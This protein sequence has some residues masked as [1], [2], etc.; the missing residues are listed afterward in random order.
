MRILAVG[1]HPDD[2]DILCAGTLAKLAKRGDKIF[3]GIL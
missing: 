3:M 1:A 2:L